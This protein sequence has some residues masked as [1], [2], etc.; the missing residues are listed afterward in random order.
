M[1]DP[2]RKSSFLRVFPQ[3]HADVAG[4][5]PAVLPC[6]LFQCIVELRGHSHRD[7]LFRFFHITTPPIVY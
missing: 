1:F 6:Q 2:E 3:N 4:D 5:G 7:V